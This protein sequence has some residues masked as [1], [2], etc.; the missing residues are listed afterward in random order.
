MQFIS[1]LIEA[2]KAFPQA[3]RE[4]DNWLLGTAF[5]LNVMQRLKAWCMKKVE[6]HMLYEN[7]PIHKKD[8]MRLACKVAIQFVNEFKSTK[9]TYNYYIAML[10]SFVAELLSIPSINRYLY[11]LISKDSLI[12]P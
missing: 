5:E 12:T 7:I 4:L 6:L 10:Y 11:P 3:E 1:D 9:E 8:Q 2:K